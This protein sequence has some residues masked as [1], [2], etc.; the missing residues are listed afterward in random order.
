VPVWG[1]SNHRLNLPVPRSMLQ[2]EGREVM[3]PP[4]AKR[5]PGTA[6]KSHAAAAGGNR[7]A[8]AAGN[9]NPAA[10]PAGKAAAVRSSKPVAV[11]QQQPKAKP[12]VSG[13]VGAAAHRGRLGGMSMQSSGM[14]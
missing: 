7:H 11:Q 13:R 2:E 5:A 4:A 10:A 1:V 12:A 3:A 14:R 8:A 6:A 9:R